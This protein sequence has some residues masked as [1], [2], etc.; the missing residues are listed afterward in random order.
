MREK[1]WLRRGLSGGK[2]RKQVM[3]DRP[4][5]GKKYKR[6]KAQEKADERC[7]KSAVRG[8]VEK[9]PNRPCERKAKSTRIL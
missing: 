6:A 8:S 3:R 2:G 9:G 4:Q 7:N 1:K 5:G